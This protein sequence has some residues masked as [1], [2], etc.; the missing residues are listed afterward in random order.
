L[1]PIL[2]PKIIPLTLLKLLQCGKIKIFIF[3][4][5]QNP[6]IAYVE[7]R[8]MRKKIDFNEVY[9]E[10]HPKIIRYISRLA[11]P[12]EAEDI[13]QEVFEKISSS[14]GGFRGESKLSTWLYRIATN[15]T[16]D[17]L[18]SVAYKHSRAQK[19]LGETDGPGT[20]S[21]EIAN[22]QAT[23]QT[24]IREEMSECVIEYINN[25]PPD[26]RTI[27]ALSE[28]EDLTNKEI[29]DILEISLENVKIRLHRAR[30]KLKTELDGGCD[31]YHNEQNVLACDRKPSQIL[32]KTPK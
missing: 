14:L 9:M 28:L 25:L 16:I 4:S 19:D 6:I 24:L 8:K 22:K 30:A 23:D 29:A 21:D 3:D 1:T 26:Y 20:Q 10:F 27:I 13:A 17:R 15:T 18:R 5:I 11:G 31:F 12:N 2:F 32:P 7:V